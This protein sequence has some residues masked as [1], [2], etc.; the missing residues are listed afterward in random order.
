M[1][2]AT[3]FGHPVEILSIEPLKDGKKFVTF[4]YADGLVQGGPLSCFDHIRGRLDS[5]DD[6]VAWLQ[7][8]NEM[9][10]GF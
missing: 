10:H 3:F 9:S 5:E 4:K 7:E 1:M 6:Q 2:T 8:T